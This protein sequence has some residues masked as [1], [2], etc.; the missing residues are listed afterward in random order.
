VADEG[1]RVSEP[2]VL[3]LGELGEQGFG[4]DIQIDE[5]SGSDWIVSRDPRDGF[6]DETEVDKKCS[7]WWSAAPTAE[8]GVG[9]RDTKRQPGRSAPDVERGVAWARPLGP[10]GASG[11]LLSAL[12]GLLHA[13]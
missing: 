11:A 13:G 9:W 10:R 5:R 7:L 4:L 2:A 12:M 8:A 6:R 3:F 1:D